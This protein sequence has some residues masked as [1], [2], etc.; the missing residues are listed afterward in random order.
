M[1]EIPVQ[2]H[3][4]L[5][6]VKY[7]CSAVPGIQS[8]HLWKERSLALLVTSV[9]DTGLP[10]PWQ[11]A[12]RPERRGL[13]LGFLKA[14]KPARHLNC[15]G[16][17]WLTRPGLDLAAYSLCWAPFEHMARNQLHFPSVLW[18]RQ[19]SESLKSAKNMQLCT[20][21]N[22]FPGSQI[23]ISRMKLQQAS[24]VMEL[25]GWRCCG[26]YG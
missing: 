24:T 3:V 14:T 7:G 25:L 10:L 5:C 13:L 11:L 4:I 2:I 22:M 20:L 15:Q 6:F 1:T 26:Q 16:S 19:D 9:G 21:Q 17:I 12:F 18:K 23:S 8:Y